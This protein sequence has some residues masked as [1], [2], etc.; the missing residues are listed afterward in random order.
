[1]CSTRRAKTGSA[2]PTNT[3]AAANDSRSLKPRDMTASRTLTGS[4]YQLRCINCGTVG[5]A[6]G[7]NLRCEQCGDLLEA[8]FPELK[9]FDRDRLKSAWLERRASYAPENTSGVWRFRELLPDLDAPYAPI[10]LREGNTPVYE[11]P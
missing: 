5:R 8:I 4:S 7:S 1:M 3:F 11:L 2:R 6:D 9:A 10:T